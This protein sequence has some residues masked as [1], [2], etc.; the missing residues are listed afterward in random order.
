MP[1]LSSPSSRSSRRGM[2]GS[3]SSRNFP[4]QLRIRVV[5]I[6]QV[7]LAVISTKPRGTGSSSPSRTTSARRRVS[8]VGSEFVGQANSLAEVGRP[9]ILG[10]EAVGRAFDEEAV[11]VD[12]FEDA[13]EGGRPLR[14]ATSSACGSE[15]GDAMRRREAA[16]ATADDGNSR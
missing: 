11:A 15:L 8:S 3:A 4:R 13:A 7:W 6:G 2:Y 10:D 14:R 9:G 1:T 5:R 16:D 12:R